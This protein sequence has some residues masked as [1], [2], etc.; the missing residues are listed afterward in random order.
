MIQRAKRRT[1]KAGD[2]LL[3]MRIEGAA[4]PTSRLAALAGVSIEA[5]DWH[6]TNLE[7]RGLIRRAGMRGR[8]QSWVA[9]AP[10]SV[11]DF[12][13][14]EAAQQRLQRMREAVRDAKRVARQARRTVGGLGARV[15]AAPA[16]RKGDYTPRR[17]PLTV[18]FFGRAR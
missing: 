2:L 13:A 6:L 18:A 8:E 15:T 10:E 3:A 1:S 9:D 7:A 5:I 17:D 4:I 16:P 12:A 11:A 14:I